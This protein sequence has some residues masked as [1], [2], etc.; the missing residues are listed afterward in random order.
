MT[1][2]PGHLWRDKWTAL[3]GPHS[4]VEWDGWDKVDAR[5]DMNERFQA[6]DAEKVR[7]RERGSERARESERERVCERVCVRERKREIERGRVCVRVRERVCE[8]SLDPRGFRGATQP[9]VHL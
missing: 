4:Q 7:K 1:D 8:D 6:I 5:W 3:S 9:S 2:P